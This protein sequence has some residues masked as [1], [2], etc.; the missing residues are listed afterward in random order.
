MNIF[1]DEATGYLVLSDI[2]GGFHILSDELYRK[3]SKRLSELESENR[4]LRA[5]NMSMQQ[6]LT[7]ASLAQSEA[8]YLQ[9]ASLNAGLALGIIGQQAAYNRAD[10]EYWLKVFQ[11]WYSE[12]LASGKFSPPP[13]RPSLGSFRP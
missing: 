7:Q 9:K 4:E 6:A 8:V 5:V 3:Q 11:M 12:A 1:R 2:T 10:I 13:S